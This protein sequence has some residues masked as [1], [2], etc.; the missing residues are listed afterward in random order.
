M[1]VS[2]IVVVLYLVA[3]GIVASQNDYFENLDNAKRILSAVLAVALW[4]FVL[5]G[6]EPR[7][8]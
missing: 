6:L 2:R 7:I 4:P 5:A 3:G 8:D 1:R